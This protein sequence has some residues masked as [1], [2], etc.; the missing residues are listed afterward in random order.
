[1]D[2]SR[3]SKYLN[4]LLTPPVLMDINMHLILIGEVPGL[5]VYVQVGKTQLLFFKHTVVLH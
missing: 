1:M 4:P 5:D 3:I 2:L